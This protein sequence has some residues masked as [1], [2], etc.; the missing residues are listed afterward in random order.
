MSEPRCPNCG[1]FTLSVERRPDGDARCALCG[2]SGKYAMCFNDQKT[3]VRI[4]SEPRQWILKADGLILSVAGGPNASLEEAERGIPVIEAEPVLA[5]IENLETQL[6]EANEALSWYADEKNWMTTR[7]DEFYEARMTI[8]QDPD[9][10][11]VI[12]EPGL[13]STLLLIGG[14]RARAYLKKWEKT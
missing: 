10:Y 9:S 8:A 5:R 1:S 7:K 4:S 2:W 14:K 13:A 11:G 6:K 3:E 12:S